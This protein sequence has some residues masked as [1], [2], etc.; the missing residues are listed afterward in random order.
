MAFRRF[1]LDRMLADPETAREIFARL[2]SRAEA[3]GALKGITGLLASRIDRDQRQVRIA[4]GPA[5]SRALKRYIAFSLAT[6]S[7]LQVEEE[8]LRA[9]ASIAIPALSSGA[10]RVLARVG[11]TL[12][13]NDR[14]LAM[15]EA[16]SDS[17]VKQ[18]LDGFA[19]AIRERF[20]ERC[21]VLASARDPDGAVFKAL[22]G[23][24]NDALKAEIRAAWPLMRIAQKLEALER[25]PGSSLRFGTLQETEDQSELSSTSETAVP[26]QTKTRHEKVTAA[27]MT[28][29]G[30][31]LQAARPDGRGAGESES[32]TA[33]RTEVETEVES[34]AQTVAEA[35]ARKATLVK[36][37]SFK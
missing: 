19:R 5:L 3:F 30:V 29:R 14:P 8:A 27:P 17:L 36:G 24:M 31:A 25:S 35:V 11:E 26:Q 7:R 37:I 22:T 23:D 18:E 33:A 2:A 15:Q 10:L 32:Q 21:L 34:K 4:N 16:F 12:D 13:R 28:E 1:G 20:G 9:R 6:R